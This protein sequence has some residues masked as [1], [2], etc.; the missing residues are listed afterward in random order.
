M[1]IVQFGVVDRA[2]GRRV[3]EYGDMEAAI[4]EERSVDE[5]EGRLG[6]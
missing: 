4:G 1:K 5:M 2:E 6:Q 3:L